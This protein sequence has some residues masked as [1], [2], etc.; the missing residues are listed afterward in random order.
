[1]THVHGGVDPLLTSICEFDLLVTIISGVEAGAVHERG[2]LRVSYP[3]F[4]QADA[5][6]VTG[7]IRR[8]L[9]THEI[10]EALLPGCTDEQLAGVLQL[11]D[12]AARRANQR[13]SGWQGYEDDTVESFINKHLAPSRQ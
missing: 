1:M 7:V 4:A 6:R 13:F 3:S 11:A 2:L 12:M 5:S 9:E 10:R 8:M